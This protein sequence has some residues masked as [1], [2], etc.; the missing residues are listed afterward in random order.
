LAGILDRMRRPARQRPTDMTATIEPP[1]PAPPVE[2]DP[3]DP[4]TAGPSVFSADASAVRNRGRV[5]DALGIGPAMRRL[6]ELCAH[7]S[8]ETPLTMLLLGAAGAG[9]SFALGRLLDDVRAFASGA[10]T[11]ARSPFLPRIAVARVKAATADEAAADIAAAI[12]HALCSPAPGGASFAGWA[13]DVAF[14]AGDPQQNVRE[15]SDRLAELRQRHDAEKQGL[16]D[17]ETRR[18]RLT[19]TLLFDSVGAQVD[20][21]VRTNRSAIES[22]LEGFGF[23]DADPVRTWKTLVRDHAANRGALARA[24]GFLYALWGYRGQMRLIVLAVLFVG[25]AW[26]IRAAE[27]PQAA[28]IADL[29]NRPSLDAVQA[30]IARNGEV[31]SLTRNAALWAAAGALLINVIRALRFRR[32]VR[33]GALLLQADVAAHRRDIDALASEGNARVADAAREVAAQTERLAHAQRRADAA[34]TVTATLAPTY[35]HAEPDSA[36]ARAQS[37]I[38]AVAARI[39]DGSPEAP[40]R[41]VTALDGLDMLPAAEAAACLR[42]ARVLLDH[43]GMVLIVASDLEHIKAG[44]RDGDGE[45]PERVAETIARLAQVTYTIGPAPDPA[46]A[47][48]VRSMIGQ[49]SPAPDAPA[50][51]AP[52]ASHSALDEPMRPGEPELLAALANMAGATPRQVKRFVNAYRLARADV[53]LFAPL[54]LAMAVECGG[55][56]EERNAFADA[57]AGARHEDAEVSAPAGPHRLAVAFRTAAAAQ[58][59]PLTASALRTARA[60]AQRFFPA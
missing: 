9:K 30:W 10:A 34:G 28:W 29:L 1:A 44:L 35:F 2:I 14:T 13:E 39:G 59:A 57:L 53:T 32:L 23:T 33:R 25:A 18:A 41:I 46:L 24:R 38:E 17:V 11:T 22:R 55:S 51:A 56:Q 16:Q 48:L 5:A 7:R 60:T 4:A 52:D 8:A 21:F 15:A 40:Q 49:K 42:Q 45:R 31:L 19:E 58:I 50:A 54:A 37:Y 26:L 47:E 27:P 3:P 12:H 6:A 20:A 43:P 36:G